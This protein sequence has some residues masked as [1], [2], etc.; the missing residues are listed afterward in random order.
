[1]NDS[2]VWQAT[3][4][5]AGS[6]GA[7]A[8]VGEFTIVS[9]NVSLKKGTRKQAVHS[10][11]LVPDHGI[12]GD[13]HAGTW[14]RQVSF[15]ADE[16]VQTM[17]RVLPGLAPGDFAENV[18]TRGVDW[19]A[20]PVGTRI[21]LGSAELELTQV[22][23]ECHGDGCAIRQAVGDCVMPRKGIFARVITG[24]EVQIESRGHYRF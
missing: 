5:S 17:R 3:P 12:A 8:T 21:F 1:M 7:A 16:A 6:P 22:G 13:A 19:A 20:L 24:G 2:S 11:T 10:V 4:A 23:K 9:L 18:T 14:H 15:L